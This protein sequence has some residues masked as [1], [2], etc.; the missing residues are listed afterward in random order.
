[1]FLYKFILKLQTDVYYSAE[2]FLQKEL[3]TFVE[4]LCLLCIENYRITNSYLHLNVQLV[5]TNAV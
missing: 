3:H 4:C 2:I 5:G 1:M